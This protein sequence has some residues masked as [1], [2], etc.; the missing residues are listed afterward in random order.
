MDGRLENLPVLSSVMWTDA[1]STSDPGD[2]RARTLGSTRI[3]L[4][5]RRTDCKVYCDREET[6]NKREVRVRG[7]AVS[8]KCNGVKSIYVG[9]AARPVVGKKRAF[10]GTD[11]VKAATAAFLCSDRD[12]LSCTLL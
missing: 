10:W 3:A 2:R 4:R 1:S 11:P 8:G 5:C 6:G 12:P 9:K 7:V